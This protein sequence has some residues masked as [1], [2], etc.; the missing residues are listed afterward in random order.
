MKAPHARGR[1]L[2]S[3]TLVSKTYKSSIKE[4]M[5]RRG[6]MNCLRVLRDSSDLQV[7]G[8]VSW[9]E[10]ANCAVTRECRNFLK[11]EPLVTVLVHSTLSINAL[12][13]LNV[14]TI[15]KGHLSWLG[16]VVSSTALR[17]YFTGITPSWLWGY[18]RHWFFDWNNI[19]TWTLYVYHERF[20][21]R[22]N[23]CSTV[24]PSDCW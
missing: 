17:L 10:F 19:T 6:L 15:L 21:W 20:T 9:F 3:T 5:K 16:M 11:Q 18:V 24:I 1:A 23:W 4:Q 7:H 22:G 13:Q 12:H 8:V 14:Y 2:S